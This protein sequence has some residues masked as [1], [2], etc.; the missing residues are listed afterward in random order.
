MIWSCRGCMLEGCLEWKVSF[1]KGNHRR[2]RSGTI[3][4]EFR[5][6]KNATVRIRA[7]DKPRYKT[8]FGWRASLRIGVRRID[9]R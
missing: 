4:D 2:G 6:D 7:R 8:T 5:D 3:L 9:H 1:R